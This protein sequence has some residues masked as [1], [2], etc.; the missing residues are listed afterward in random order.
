MEW[1][2]WTGAAVSLA[3][4]LGLFWCIF[5]VWSAKRAGM[6]DEA[7]RAVMRKIVPINMGALLLSVFGLVMVLIGVMLG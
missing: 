6:D 4:L 3:G 1:L 2:I 7:L 5:R